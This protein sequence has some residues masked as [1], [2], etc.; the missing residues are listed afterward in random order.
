[1][2]TQQPHHH[3]THQPHQPH[4]TFFGAVRGEFIKA[5]SLVSTWVLLIINTLLLPAGTAVMAWAL[6]FF[7]TR[8]ANGD[9]AGQPAFIN[10]ALLWQSVTASV[11]MC[12]IVIAVFGVMSITTEYS[13]LS[14]QASLTANPRRAMFMNAKALVTVLLAFA[15]SLIGLLLSWGIATALFAGLTT[16]P[17]ADSQ[18]ALPIIALLGGAAVIAATAL[19]SLGFGALFRSTV[20]GIL[21]VI[22]LLMIVPSILSM[23]TLAG[24]RMNWVYSVINCLPDSASSAFLAGPSSD[25]GLNA[26]AGA[27]GMSFGPTE[28]VFTP[29]WWQSGL[30][31]LAWALIVYIA[32][33]IAVRRSDV[34]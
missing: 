5:F 28:G 26:V 18:R 32:G 13:T 9:N 31:L 17:L 27:T 4:L 1:P 19:L 6:V 21:T 29:N 20:G 11:S 23:T 22:G 8:S 30:I 14:V 12:M 16:T 24:E 33:V 3:G 7:A 25:T 15:S 34:K 10:G 2:Q